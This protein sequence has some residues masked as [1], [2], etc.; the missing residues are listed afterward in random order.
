MTNVTIIDEI[1]AKLEDHPHIHHPAEI[2][3]SER[4]GDVTLRGSV[5]SFKERQ[6]AVQVAKSVR[7]VR[8]VEDQLMVDLRNHWDDDVIRGLALQA[9]MSSDDVPADRVDV[10]VDGG[11]L[12]LK[13]EVK[14]QFDSDAAFAV[15]SGVPGVGGITNE[16]KVIT[17]GID[18]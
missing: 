17:A 9:L 5:G 13:G 16:I 10:K 6:A 1:R 12:T 11:W 3:I 8:A 4:E 2:A 15:V 7:A 14:H 18:G